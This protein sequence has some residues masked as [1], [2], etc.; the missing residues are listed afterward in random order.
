M[1]ITCL[2]QVKVQILTSSSPS[3]NLVL[4]YLG[5]FIMLLLLVKRVI[6]ASTMKLVEN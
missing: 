2:K 3:M 5:H 6:F 4:K 1:I